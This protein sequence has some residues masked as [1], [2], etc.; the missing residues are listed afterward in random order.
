[1]KDKTTQIISQKDINTFLSSQKEKN[2]VLY[3]LFAILYYTG[4]RTGELLGFRSDTFIPETQE[5]FIV[6]RFCLRSYSLLRHD[7]D[8]FDVLNSERRLQVPKEV[9]Y[10][11]TEGTLTTLFQITDKRHRIAEEMRKEFKRYFPN[12]PIHSLRVSRLVHLHQDG[13]NTKELM[14]FFDFKSK[15]TI[16]RYL[17]EGN[18]SIEV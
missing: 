9:L 15:Q 10:L 18:R 1:M 11:F 7:S 5:L 14:M 13:V 17:E 16:M 4:L 3:P 12:N 8:D 6:R 2:S